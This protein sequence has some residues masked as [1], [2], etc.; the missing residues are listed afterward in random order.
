MKNVFISKVLGLAMLFVVSIGSFTET[1]AQSEL[2]PLAIVVI[3]SIDESCD[4]LRESGNLQTRCKNNDCVTVAC[5]SLRRACD[6]PA[7]CE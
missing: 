4:N 1:K 5:I 3:E 6:S 7:D 2:I